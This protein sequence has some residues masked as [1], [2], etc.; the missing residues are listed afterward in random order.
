MRQGMCGGRM[1]GSRM[2]GAADTGA[3]RMTGS[4]GE[5]PAAAGMTGSAA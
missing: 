2:R 4:A 3:G 5:P 1:S